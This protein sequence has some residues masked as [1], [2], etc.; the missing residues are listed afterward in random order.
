[1][2]NKNKENIWID[3]IIIILLLVKLQNTLK[4]VIYAAF[5]NLYKSYNQDF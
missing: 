4:R 3:N 1:M 5:V 2:K